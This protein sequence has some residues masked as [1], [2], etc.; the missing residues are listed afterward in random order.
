MANRTRYGIDWEATSLHCVFA[1]LAGIA[2]VVLIAPS[3]IVLLMSLTSSVS[4]RFPP[5]GLSLRWYAALLDAE[6][7]QRAAWNSLVVA[8]WTTTIRPS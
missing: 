4:L 8:F 5:P 2:I 1:V 7:M 6:Q 3:L